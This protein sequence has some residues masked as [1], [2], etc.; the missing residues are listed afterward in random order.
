MIFMII[1]KHARSGKAAQVLQQ[2]EA[3]IAASG[4]QVEARETAYAGHAKELADACCSEIASSGETGYLLAVGGDGTFNEIINGMHD[5]DRVCLCLIPMGSGND[6]GRGLRISAKDPAARMRKVLSMIRKRLES[7]EEAKNNPAFIRHMD[8]GQVTFPDGSARRF[9]ISAGIGVDA[10]VCR[11]VDH[12]PI[13]KILNKIG[14]GS[15]SYVILTVANIFHMPLCDGELETKDG[16]VH[17]FRDIIFCAAMNHICEGGGVPMA[18][19][20]SAFD[21]KL[22]ICAVHSIP[23]WKCFLDLPVLVMAKHGR[24]KGFE[25]FDSSRMKIRLAQPMTVH[26]DGEYCGEWNALEFACLPGQ[27]QV[28]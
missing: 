20:A 1:N 19:Q 10:A 18:P 12:S 4:L 15:L 7:E 6:L 25:L 14:L 5:F 17:A 16:T 13:K 27:L 21:G 2:L 8:L 23:R 11:D 26:A 3:E 28:M 22:S 24:L 9:A